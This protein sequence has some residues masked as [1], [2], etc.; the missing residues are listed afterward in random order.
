MIV[1]ALS[2]KHAVL[3]LLGLLDSGEVS[4]MTIM[5]FGPSI[6]TIDALLDTLKKEDLLSVKEERRGRR[7]F[8]ISLTEKG[9]KVA[10]IL[11]SIRKM[12]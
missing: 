3:V 12:G 2:E 10:E 6:N 1:K 11:D 5:K 9:R 8:L 7:V 4:K